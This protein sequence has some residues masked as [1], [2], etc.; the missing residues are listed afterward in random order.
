MR[1]YRTTTTQGLVSDLLSDDCTNDSE[2]TSI[3]RAECGAALLVE[4]TIL[5]AM[6]SE[7]Y[8]LLRTR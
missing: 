8:R 7:I 1:K 5:L 4:E 6:L 2:V 3:S